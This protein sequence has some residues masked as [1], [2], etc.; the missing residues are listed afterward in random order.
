MDWPSL[1]VWVNG[2]Q[3]QNVNVATVPELRNRFRSG[4]IGIESLSY[5]LRFRN[6]EIKELPGKEKWEVLYDS[7]ADMAKWIVAEGKATWEPLGRVLRADGSGY[8][9]TRDQS[10]KDF[11]FQCYIRAVKHHNGGII[12]R[13]ATVDTWKHH[14]IQLH[15]VEGAVYPTGSLYHF[16]RAKYP[17]IT[18]EQW[19]PFQLIVK[20]KDCLVRINGEDVMEYHDVPLMSPGPIMLQAHQNGRWIEYKEIKI[21]K[22]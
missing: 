2:E 6:L 21:R 14:E 3:V 4:Y 15:D 11:E 9:A 5:P 20:D 10:Y 22:L 8:L 13:G 18:P 16:K 12:F 17:R 19:F 1:Q 7:P